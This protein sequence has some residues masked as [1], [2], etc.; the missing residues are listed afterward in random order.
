MLFYISDVKRNEFL[1]KFLLKL[2]P[3]QHYYVSSFLTVSIFISSGFQT[4]GY[5]LDFGLEKFTLFSYFF[6]DIIGSH[7]IGSH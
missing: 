7:Q 6:I 5:N 4:T 1:H 3:R 2:D